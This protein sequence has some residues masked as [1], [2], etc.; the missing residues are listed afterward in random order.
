M[1]KQITILA[2]M[3]LTHQLATAQL[4]P[5]TIEG[6]IKGDHKGYV[7]LS[8]GTGSRSSQL[9]SAQV[10][11][12]RFSFR[13]EL[14]HA[15]SAGIFLKM[16]RVWTGNEDAGNVY[17]E[18]G[19]MKLSLVKGDLRHA[20]LTGSAAQA[21]DDRLEAATA[22]AR[23]KLEPL[24]KAF[25]ALNEKYIAA[26]RAKKDEATLEKM[27]KDLD[28]IKT[29]MEPYQ[30]QIS[31]ETIQFIKKN[32]DS[33]VTVN[34]MRFY[35]SQMKV[36]EGEAV[37]AAMPADKQQSSLGKE[38]KKELEGMRMG[39]PGSTAFVFSKKDIN[40]ETIDLASLKGKYVLIDFWASW[41]G[42][43]R[44]GNP[45]LKSLY[46]KYKDKGFEIIGISDD[47]SDHNAWKKAVEKDGIGIWKHALRGLDME[48]AMKGEENPNDI[49]DK[50]GIHSLP[51]KILID[52][53][54]VIIGRY[55]GGGEDDDA[56]DKKL[57]EIFGS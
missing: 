17:I 51:T 7:Y 41:C 46:G 39:S 29:K 34:M 21:D 28:A 16:S 55:G 38:L 13:G 54:G 9:D 11:N 47:D 22:A 5:F 33:W 12:G 32:P 24:S 35:V 3:A 2:G 48:K 26:M 40:G 37:Y 45:H 15:V 52:Q 49:S 56:M 30:E 18:P 1:I 4:K 25:S 14:P 20:K 43:C 50:Y 31:E 53:N 6:T 44:K 10:K 19:N 36:D 57:K 27:K 23:V 42:P 8:Y